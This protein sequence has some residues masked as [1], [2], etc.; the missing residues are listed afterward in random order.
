MA[1]TTYSELQTAVANWL[2][3]SD[4]TSQIPEFIDLTE[5]DIRTDL[6]DSQMET[7]AYATTSISSA[8]LAFPDDFRSIRR[9]QIVYG[10]VEYLIEERTPSELARYDDSGT[11]LPRYFAVIGDQFQ[12]WPAPD[13]GY[14]VEITYH[15]D[16]PALSDSNTSNWLLT[17]APNLYLYGACKHAAVYIRDNEMLSISGA[18]YGQALEKMIK[19]NQRRKYGAHPLRT[20]A[21]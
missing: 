11:G 17:D 4:L 7:R 5:A 12:F 14:R 10:G 19:Q 9:M 2:N 18:L 8:Y 3:R 15:K 16:V 1:I 21:V 20:K 6:Y 13:A